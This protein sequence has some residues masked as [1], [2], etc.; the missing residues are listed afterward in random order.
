MRQA[1]ALILSISA[2]HL[3]FLAFVLNMFGSAGPDASGGGHR[4]DGAKAT[5]NYPQLKLEE[6]EKMF[7]K[8]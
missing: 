1:L 5:E 4:G 8:F 7:L 3:A 6:A 2:L